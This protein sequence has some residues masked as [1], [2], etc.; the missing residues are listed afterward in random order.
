LGRRGGTLNKK[1]KPARGRSKK[2]NNTE[3]VGVQKRSV[4]QGEKGRYKAKNKGGRGYNLFKFPRERTGR[5]IKRQKKVFGQREKGTYR[6]KKKKGKE[7]LPGGKKKEEPC[8]PVL[9]KSNP[10]NS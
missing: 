8:S 1:P 3:K 7:E 2:K 10:L 6:R 5:E 4:F 9:W